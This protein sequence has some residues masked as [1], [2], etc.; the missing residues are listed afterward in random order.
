M[1]FLWY[2]NIYNTPF[3]TIICRH[4]CATEN[5]M[6]MSWVISGCLRKFIMFNLGVVCFVVFVLSLCR[7]FTWLCEL[8]QVSRCLCVSAPIAGQIWHVGSLDI[9]GHAW[10]KSDEHL[11][12]WNAKRFYPLNTTECSGKQHL[13][14]TTNDKRAK[15]GC[16]L[17]VFGPIFYH[18]L[19]V[20]TSG[21]CVLTSCPYCSA[22]P[23]TSA[24]ACLRPQHK[25][26]SN[27]ATLPS[28]K[29]WIKLNYTYK[30]PRPLV[31]VQPTFLRG[32][33]AIFR[34]C[35]T[36]LC[37]VFIAMGPGEWTAEWQI[38]PNPNQRAQLVT[39]TPVPMKVLQK[40]TNFVDNEHCTMC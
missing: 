33:Y 12:W 36:V 39:T 19:Q 1:S 18:R 2:Q 29:S 32:W 20:S 16:L 37:F 10:M 5:K 34:I 9:S 15:R 40:S 6:C 22:L 35:K 27:I 21:L 25:S 28:I 26:S 13:N 4:T 30:T 3:I 8:F 17:E 31:L 11:T 24:R 23:A 38:Q 7:D 14:K